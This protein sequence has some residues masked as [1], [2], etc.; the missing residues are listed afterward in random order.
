M[1]YTKDLDLNIK[2]LRLTDL[3]SYTSTL[4][5]SSSESARIVEQTNNVELYGDLDALKY[6]DHQTLENEGLINY[7]L[8]AT[9]YDSNNNNNNNSRTPCSGYSFTASY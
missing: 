1:K 6:L 4:M 2:K 7:K 9:N 8:F 3:E 5:S